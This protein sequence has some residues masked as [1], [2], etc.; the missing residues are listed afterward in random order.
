VLSDLSQLN[1]LAIQID[2]LPIREES[3]RRSIYIRQSG[4]RSARPGRSVTRRAPS[5]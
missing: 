3:A 4:K 1:L 5:S 2:G